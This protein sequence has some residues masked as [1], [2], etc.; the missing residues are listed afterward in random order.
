[1]KYIYLLT[2]KITNGIYI[3][4]TS[5]PKRRMWEHK[6]HMNTEQSK[7]IR[8]YT[9]MREYGFENFEL[10][11]LEKIPSS[12]SDEK[13]AYYINKYNA[14]SS[15]N[16][17]ELT[18]YNLINENSHE[19]IITDYRNGLSA[20]KIGKK[21]G[22]KHPQIIKI[23]K[24]NLS[25]SEYNSLSHKLPKKNIPIEDIVDLIEKQHKSKKETAQI[26]GVCDSTVVRR[27]NKWKKSNDPN[28]TSNPHGYGN[29]KVDENLIINTY[30]KLKS[31]R[32]TADETGYSR[33][34]VRRYLKKVNML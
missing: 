11:I 30:S 12:Q 24:E 15:E 29:K 31:T 18:G 3:G 19:R 32:K 9:A 1:M 2:N 4:Q 13:E 28:Y 20:S 14:T 26:L 22:V 23:L 34:T 16:Y 6:S 25:E 33:S 7:N 17:N 8:L 5:N 10:T 21:Y 27:Y